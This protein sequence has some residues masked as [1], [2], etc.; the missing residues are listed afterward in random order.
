L[1]PRTFNSDIAAERA[2]FAFLYQIETSGG[3]IRLTNASRDI[4][5]LSQ[6]WTAVGG[7]LLQGVVPDIA[8]RRAQGVDLT[9]FG[10]SQTIIALL[11]LE[12]FRGRNVLIYLIQGDPDTQVFTTPDLIFRGRQNSDYRITEDRDFESTE[13]GGTVT[14]KTRISA[15]LSQINSAISCR[16]SVPSHQEFLRRA[17]LSTSDDFFSRVFSIMNKTIFWG[18]ADPDIPALQI[19]TTIYGVPIYSDT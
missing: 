2:E 15:D 6:T 3:T 17:G 16:S 7:S 14:V 12:Q 5:A 1:S 4:V 9:L 10:V 8:D 13:S 18:T 11:Q 19:G